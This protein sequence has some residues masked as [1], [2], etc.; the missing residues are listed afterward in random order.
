M[1]A[2]PPHPKVQTAKQLT[3]L[4]DKGPKLL[5]NLPKIALHPTQQIHSSE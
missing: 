1:D 5:R 4:H 3:I 2:I